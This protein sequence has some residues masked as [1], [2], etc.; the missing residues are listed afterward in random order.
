MKSR[1]TIYISMTSLSRPAHRWEINASVPVLGCL[2]PPL[3]RSALCRRRR[4][5]DRQK[6]RALRC[7][8]RLPSL[9]RCHEYLCA[10]RSFACNGP[11]TRSLSF[12]GLFYLSGVPESGANCPDVS[13]QMMFLPSPPF[14]SSIRLPLYLPL[15]SISLSQ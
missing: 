13:P 5:T 1:R 3:W 2:L 11:H 8:K 10:D 4:P 6:T 7:I 15:H 14:L 9:P 12:G